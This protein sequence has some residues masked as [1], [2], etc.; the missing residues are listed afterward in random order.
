[1]FC[2]LD[3]SLSDKGESKLP[4][5]ILHFSISPCISII[6]VFCFDALL[7]GAYTL[8]IVLFLG[9]LIPLSLS[10]PSWSL[11]TSLA[12]KFPL[13]EINVV[14]PAFFWLVLLWSIFLHPFT[15]NLCLLFKARFLWI[16]YGWVFFFNLLWQP[17][18]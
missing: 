12:L 18:F 13:L 16:T 11:I 2:L 15:F 17:I 6:F 3:L 10:M 9:E 5:L 7:L 8:K 1:M 14:L 4:P